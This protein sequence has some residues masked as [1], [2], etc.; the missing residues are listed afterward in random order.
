LS[1]DGLRTAIHGREQNNVDVFLLDA[2]RQVRFTV[3]ASND[4]FPIWSPNGQ[5]VVFDSNRSGVRDLYWKPL[6][7]GAG[8]EELLL[9]SSYPKAAA[10]WSRDGRF[11]L[12]SNL[13]GNGL[14]DLWVLPIENG[15]PGNPSEFHGTRFN[16]CC[17][18]FSPSGRWV[19]YQSDESGQWQIYIRPFP[20]TG[21]QWPVSTS[22]GIQV[23]WAFDGKE[24]YYIAPDGALM[25]APIA[26]KGDL[27]EIGNPVALFRTRIWTSGTLPTTRQQYDVAPDGRFLINVALDEAT[28]API[29]LPL[30]WKPAN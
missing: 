13:G 4:N 9:K 3:D 18:Q 17:G 14:W 23:R 15:K 19:A 27:V 29:T 6:N 12:Y 28:N 26:E 24:L 16:E 30:N 7:G 21:E 8:S 10:D 25:A 20:A 2:A 22:G 1:R 5:R 11:I